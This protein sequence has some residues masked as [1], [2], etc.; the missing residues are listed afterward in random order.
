MQLYLIL[1][2]APVKFFIFILIPAKFESFERAPEQESLMSC[3]H[4]ID[5]TVADY[6][7]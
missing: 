4:F 3:Y 2:R 7:E 6:A 5:V 1:K